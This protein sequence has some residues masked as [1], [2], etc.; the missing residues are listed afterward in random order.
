MLNKFIVVMMV[1]AT[2]AGCAGKQGRSAS[3]NASP[4]FKSTPVS[5]VTETGEPSGFLGET[6]ILKG[7][8][9]LIKSQGAETVA[10]LSGCSLEDVTLVDTK[11]AAPQ[12][13]GRWQ[14]DWMYE[15]CSSGK[16]AVPV[17]LKSGLMGRDWLQ[18]KVGEIVHSE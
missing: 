2:L 18:I 14:E 17:T 13:N 9:K 6:R 1:G 12:E 4:A 7:M 11:R 5:F 3:A 8:A 10:S 15:T 16:Y